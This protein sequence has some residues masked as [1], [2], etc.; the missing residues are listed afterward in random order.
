[1]TRSSVSFWLVIRMVPSGWTDLLPDG[2]ARTTPVPLM[3]SRS[4]GSSGRAALRAAG[5]AL[6][7]LRGASEVE[8]VGLVAVRV[9]VQSCGFTRAVL[10]ASESEA[11]AVCCACGDDVPLEGVRVGRRGRVSTR[12]VFN[13]LHAAVL[14]TGGVGL[15]VDADRAVAVAAPVCPQDVAIGLLVADRGRDSELSDHAVD[16]DTIAVVA[17]GVGLAVERADLRGR[18]QAQRRHIRR[19]ALTGDAL[20]TELCETPTVLAAAGSSD[21]AVLPTQFRA[22]HQNGGVSTVASADSRLSGRECE[23][24]D[25]ITEGLRNREIAGRLCIT[26][27]TVKSHVRRILRKLG[28][29]NR[30]EAVSRYRARG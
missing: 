6:A 24:L 15:G 26:E 19:L 7:A 18:L 9:L 16:R 27:D 1:M 12:D 3:E 13:R 10:W 22:G 21:F 4:I 25:L 23:V 17:E 20:L 2:R 30:A 28:A 29:S 8:E 14:P 5:G 11:L